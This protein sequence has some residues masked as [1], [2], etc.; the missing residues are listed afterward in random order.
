LNWVPK[1]NSKETIKFTLDWYTNFSNLGKKLCDYT[2]FQI[3]Y[4]FNL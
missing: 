4:F 1:L 2:S 3:N